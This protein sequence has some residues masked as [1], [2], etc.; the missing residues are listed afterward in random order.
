[1][2]ARFYQQYGKLLLLGVAL[3]FPWLYMRAEAI[4]S[5]NDIETWLPHGTAV[6]QAYDD[7]K[8]EFGADE[9]LIIGLPGQTNP[10]LVEAVAGR[11]ERVPGIRS[12][13]TSERLVTR[14]TYLGVPEAEAQQ[15]LVGLVADP[16]GK[17]TGL[18]AFLS[19]AG[20]KDR[21][22][23]V[24]GIRQ[25]IAYC[26]IPAQDAALTGAPVIVNELDRLGNQHSGRPYF[27]LTLLISLGLLQYSLRHWGMSLSVLGLTI[28]GI[29]ANQ[30]LVAALGG[31]MNFIMGSLSVMVTIFTL[32]I[33]I[34]FL[35]YYQDAMDAG[36]PDPLGQALKLSW[37]PCW[38]STLTTL[39]GLLSL[40]VSSILPVCQFGYAAAAGSVMALIVGLGLTPAL[41]IVYPNFRM[42]A[43][44]STWNFGRLADLIARRKGWILAGTV[45]AMAGF[46]MGLS[47]LKSDIDPV[48][49]LPRGNA[50]FADL[51]RIER[52]LT[53]IDSLEGVVEFRDDQQSFPEKL[54]IVRNIE[55]RI[56]QH[57]SVRH[58]ISLATFFPAQDS[59][60]SDTASLT[61]ASR[62]EGSADLLTPNRRLWRISA[63]LRRNAQ[64][65]PVAV[66]DQLTRDL[67]D[68]PIH[69]TGLTPLLKSAQQ[70]IFD[71]FWQSFLGACITISA[72]MIFSLRSLRAGLI[73]MVPNIIPIWMVFGAVGFIGMPVDIGMMMTGSIALGISVDCTFHFLVAYRQAVQQG[74]APETACRVALSHCGAP[75]LSS[76]LIG[77]VGMLA[78]CL[79]PFAPTVRFGLLMAAQ[80]FAS[81][82]GELLILPAMLCALERSPRRRVVA[83]HPVLAEE[84]ASDA[85]WDR[86]FAYGLLARDAAESNG[87]PLDEESRVARRLAEVFAKM[88][89][90]E[91][92]PVKIAPAPTPLPRVRVLLE[93][94]PT[95]TVMA[96]PQINEASE[97]TMIEVAAIEF[98]E[99][100]TP[101]DEV[102]GILDDDMLE[103]IDAPH[104]QAEEQDGED[105][106]EVAELIA[107]AAFEDDHA[108]LIALG[109]EDEVADADSPA[110]EVILDAELIEESAFEAAAAVAEEPADELDA[111]LASIPFTQ[112]A[113]NAEDADASN[114]RAGHRIEFTEPHFRLSRRVSR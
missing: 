48:E 85:D 25:A 77:G 72:V 10:A 45:V 41:V 104:N 76:T 4:K 21:G 62:L 22:G 90:L 19:E 57:P 37:N 67:K 71:G 9:V 89:Q 111:W 51:Q 55:Q 65:S 3:S 2:I 84:T 106:L 79:S 28:W 75:M 52:D 42:R 36:D 30:S 12:C 13:A 82:L 100:P 107:E 109:L 35:S 54:E 50:I 98:E 18:L 93:G 59:T 5:N 1:M 74:C 88:D 11:I 81:L 31:E 56:A 114:N 46:G 49:F 40:N 38:L 96:T 17:T 34:H 14:M 69:F 26:Q 7:F 66:L 73:A 92:P 70:E 16:A 24:A 8:A 94:S 20:L 112:Y 39:L 113:A 53:S 68:V 91:T 105:E 58:V 101:V 47:R 63:R 61:R 60:L 27:L 95:V 108:L 99:V 15:R 23:V 78:L 97:P 103:V 86:E 83:G 87:E 33:A 110:E 80:A 29:Q 6:R 102:T 32:S 44:E 43:A 64:H